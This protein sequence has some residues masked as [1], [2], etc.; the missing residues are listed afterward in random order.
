MHL[1]IIITN[2]KHMLRVRRGGRVVANDEKDFNFLFAHMKREM[3]STQDGKGRS[4]SSLVP[5]EAGLLTSRL[6]SYFAWWNPQLP[7]PLASWLW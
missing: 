1:Q 3:P 7:W 4:L 2:S 5:G 6:R